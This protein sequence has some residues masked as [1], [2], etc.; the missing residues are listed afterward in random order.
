MVVVR[1]VPDCGNAPR[2]VV[3]RDLVI[4]LAERDADAVVAP[5]ADDVRWSL[6]GDVE[7]V[8]ADAVR[9]WGAGLPEADE[10]TFEAVLTH[11]RMAAVDGSVIAADG[12]QEDFCHVLHFAGAAKTAEIVR[13][14]SYRST[15]R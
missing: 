14:R 6:V 13:V 11:G 5:L 4:G 2:K 8:G 12:A 10:L 9:V 7:L 15:S 3:L 1:G